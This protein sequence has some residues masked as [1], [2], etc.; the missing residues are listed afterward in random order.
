MKGTAR[1]RLRTR[2]EAA[3][4]YTAPRRR[5]LRPRPSR[6]GHKSVKALLGNLLMTLG[7]I[8]ACVLCALAIFAAPVLGGVAAALGVISVFAAFEFSRRKRWEGNLKSRLARVEEEQ[9]NTRDHLKMHDEDISALKARTLRQGR[10][11]EEHDYS[12]RSAA[13][14]AGIDTQGIPQGIMPAHYKKK[15]I[16]PFTK[17][18]ATSSLIA[19][20][21]PFAENASLSGAVVQELLHQA[22]RDERIEVFMQPIVRLPQRKAVGYEFF[23]RIRAK[24]GL[25]VPAGR[26]MKIAQK[27]KLQSE[28]DILLLQESLKNLKKHTA[29][30][31]IEDGTVF[32]I[33]IAPTTLRHK[34]YMSVLLSFIAR[35]RELAS[36]LVFEMT[37]EAFEDMDEGSAKILQALGKL[38]CSFSLDHVE[39][40]HFNIEKYAALHVHYIKVNS[41]VLLNKNNGDTSF[42]N[43]SK[44]KRALE[45]HNIRAIAGRV[46]NE[47]TIRELLDFDLRYGQGF[48]FGKPDLQ[49]A[50]K[51]FAYSRKSYKRVGIKEGFA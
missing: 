12:H 47:Y 20:D 6:K 26:Y 17:S 46:E 21:D 39:T 33:N 8:T 45:R 44:A 41:D 43:W 51:P 42:R 30:N 22:I 1:Q 32:F 10:Q 50:Y 23:A 13:K 9:Q 29:K 28:I 31:H 36:Q 7:A 35:N 16:R 25:Y 34:K 49:G 24:A 4:G 18:T 14:A 37:Q 19:N 15:D 11:A 48:L 38:G 3:M 2:R 5:V 27:D 40:L